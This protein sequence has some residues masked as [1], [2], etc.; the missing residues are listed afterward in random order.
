ML[1]GR[2]RWPLV[3]EVVRELGIL[4][5]VFGLLDF[6]Y[7]ISEG[8]T[9]RVGWWWVAVYVAAGIGLIVVGLYMGFASD[10]SDSVPKK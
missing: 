6:V 1:K 2:Q 8:N 7:Q 5:S 4:M 3:S 9:P 10:E